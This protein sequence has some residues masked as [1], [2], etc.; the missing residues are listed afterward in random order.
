MAAP[1]RL[2]ALRMPKSGEPAKIW[3]IN[4]VNGKNYKLDEN[5]WVVG[6][7]KWLSTVVG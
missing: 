1:T 7:F 6:S 4:V 5:N 3:K 2:S